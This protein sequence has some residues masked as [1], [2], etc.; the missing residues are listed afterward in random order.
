MINKKVNVIVDLGNYNVKCACEGKTFKFSS[1][2]DN[3]FNANNELFDRINYNGVTT[4]IG[5][6]K[7]D[8]EFN[9]TDKNYMPSLLYAISQATESENINLCLL[10]P[11]NQM[12]QKAK[13][14]E[15]LKSKT[16]EFEVNGYQ[17]KVTINEMT[18]LPESYTSYYML[19]ESAK[20]DYVAIIDIGS[21][22]VNLTTMAKSNL[23]KTN[24]F[25]LGTFNFYSMIRKLEDSNGNNYTEEEIERLIDRGVIKV[26][27]SIYNDFFKM[28]LNEIKAEISNLK[29]YEVYF[30]GGGSL[31]LEKYIKSLK[32]KNIHIVDN[33][34]FSNVKGAEKL[35]SK[36]WGK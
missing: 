6:G 36:V 5:V 22:T 9:K 4:K 30:C 2:I 17:R 26:Q 32:L 3:T 15:E 7:L 29:A 13:F 25:A 24:T 20:N 14:I 19:N 16:F 11:N 18:V 21:R 8:R 28:L 33:A 34:E 10:L 23:E 27:S 1:K 12:T 35:C 31:L